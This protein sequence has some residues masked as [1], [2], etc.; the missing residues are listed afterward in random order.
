MNISDYLKVKNTK[1][2]TFKKITKNCSQTQKRKI[3]QKL[4][5]PEI[6]PTYLGKIPGKGPVEKRTIK[7][8]CES[9][10]EVALIKKYFKISEYKELNIRDISL[11]L[12]LLT[13]LEEGIL[14]YE[15]NTLF[16]IHENGEEIKLG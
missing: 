6:L 12:K 8:I 15:K 2:S 1:S 3:E 4:L 14:K 9:E 16:F 5:K 10:I 7:I 13:A 11:L